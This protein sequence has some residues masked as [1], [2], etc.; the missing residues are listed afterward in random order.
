MPIYLNC[1]HCGHPQ[2]VPAFRRGRKRLCRQCGHGYQTSLTAN[3]VR[4]LPIACIGDS[5]A[6]SCHGQRVFVLDA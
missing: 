5:H 1:P 2:V 3:E 4:P 6:R